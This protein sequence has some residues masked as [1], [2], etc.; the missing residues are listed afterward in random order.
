ME[1]KLIAIGLDCGVNLLE[2]GR[3]KSGVGLFRRPVLIS[4][5]FESEFGFPIDIHTLSLAF[6]LFVTCLN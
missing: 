6:S 1:V 4:G 5:G 2:F 3:N